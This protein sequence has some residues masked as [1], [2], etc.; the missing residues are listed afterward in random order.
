MNRSSLN[1]I[2]RTRTDAEPVTFD[3]APMVDVVLLLLIF[4][5][6]TSNLST[7]RSS[8]PLDLPRASSTVN[9]TPQIPTVS[10]DER[11]QIF[12]E[13]RQVTA[14]Q[15]ERALPELVKTSGGVVAVRADAK[16]QYG[17]VVTV[18]DVIKRAGGE[19]LAL[20]ARQP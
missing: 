7:S 8:V 15:L 20:G 14:A 18:I 6:L 5:F 3:F 13:D 11:G 12:L 9:D 16:G 1:R 19:R 10:I 2:R 4:F 17:Q